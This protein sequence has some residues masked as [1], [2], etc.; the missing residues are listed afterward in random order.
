MTDPVAD[1]LTRIRNAQMTGKAEVS[2]PGSKLKLALANALKEE[3]YIND[4]SVTMDGGKATLSVRLKYYRGKPVISMVKRVSRPGIRIYKGKDD[5][6]KIMGGLGV[7]LI[8]T[9]S[10]IMSDRAARKAGVGGE[11][12]CYVA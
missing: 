8:S 3:G 7:A 12:L 2:I 11:V 10:G 9:S 6:P 5:L 4:V 1:M